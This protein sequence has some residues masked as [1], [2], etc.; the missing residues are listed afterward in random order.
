M[1]RTS[2]GCVTV[3]QYA[4]V[5]IIRGVGAAQWHEI[6][7]GEEVGPCAAQHRREGHAELF[8]ETDRVILNDGGV[9][10]AVLY[11]SNRPQTHGDNVIV[12]EAGAGSS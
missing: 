1:L 12:R 7:R 6:G 10:V 2:G 5:Q 9:L 4:F 8:V 3:A 11:W